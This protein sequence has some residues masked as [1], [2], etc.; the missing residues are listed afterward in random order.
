MKTYNVTCSICGH[1]NCNLLLEE[2]DG[3]ME[4]ENCK[5]LTRTVRTEKMVKIPV[6]SMHR[7]KQEAV[8][9]CLAK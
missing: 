3:W 5:Q 4:C 6:F 2:T 1:L 9:A 8:V 7:T